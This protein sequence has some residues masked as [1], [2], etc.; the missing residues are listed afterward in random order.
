VDLATVY[1]YQEIKKE[2]RSTYYPVMK[3][4]RELRE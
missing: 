2:N 4:S 3:I 1:H